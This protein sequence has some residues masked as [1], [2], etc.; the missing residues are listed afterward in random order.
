[1]NPFGSGGGEDPRPVDGDRSRYSSRSQYYGEPETRYGRNRS[2]SGRDADRYTTSERYPRAYSRDVS[3]D[4]RYYGSP[5]RRQSYGRYH[6]GGSLDRY[7]TSRSRFSISQYGDY[8]G[9][10]NGRVYVDDRYY[11][12]EPRYLDRYSKYREMDYHGPSRERMMPR[13]DDYGRS[14]SR[15]GYDRPMPIDR[16]ERYAYGSGDRYAYAGDRDYYT[17]HPSDRY[18]PSYE[19]PPYDRYGPGSRYAIDRYTIRYGLDRSHFEDHFLQDRHARYPR[20]QSTG[21]RVR[22]DSG[23]QY[24]E[25]Q[26]RG[27]MSD[28]QD[29]F[30]TRRD[31]EPRTESVSRDHSLPPRKD[32]EEDYRTDNVANINRKFEPHLQEIPT[33]LQQESRQESRRGSEREERRGSEREERRGSEREERR[34]SERE[35]RRGSERQFDMQDAGTGGGSQTHISGQFGSQAGSER[36][37]TTPTPTFPEPRSTYPQTM[38]ISWDDEENYR[39]GSAARSRELALRASF[40][41]MRRRPRDPSVDVPQRRG[42]SLEPEL[43]IPLPEDILKVESSDFRPVENSKGHRTFEYELVNDAEL[44][45]PVYRRGQTFR[46]HVVLKERELEQSR[47]NMY[48]NFFFGPTPSVPKRTRVVLPIV[49]GAEFQR[50]PYQWDAR[51]L[52]TDGTAMIIEVN[53]PSSCPVGLW[54]CVIETSSADNPSYRL[55]YRC[56]DDVYIIFNPFEREDTV[57]MENDEQRYEYVIN[58]TGKIYTGGYR[59]VRGRPWV[60]GQFDECVLPAACVLLEM[61]GLSHSERG[62]PVKVSRAIA[63]MI[64]ATRS[65]SKVETVWDVI[66]PG[67]IEPRF[68][69][70][71]LRVG[72]S[73]H[74]WTGSVQIIEEFLKGGAAPVKYAQCWVMAA[75]MTSLCRALGL[76]ARPVTAYV[77]ALDTQD[78]LTVDRYIDRFGDI[79]EHG[80]SRDQPDSV[81]SFHTWCDVWMHRPDQTPEYSGWQATDPCRTYRDFRDLFSGSCGPCPIEA[82]R[83][84]DIGQRDDVDAFYASLNSYVRYFYEDDESGWGFSPFKQFRYPVSRYILTKSV[85]RFDDDGDNDCDD[86]T[87]VYRDNELT[88]AERFAIFNS[89]RGL[90]KDTPAYEYK[91]AAFDLKQFDPDQGDQKKFDVSFELDAPERVMVGQPLIVPV[92]V[93][94]SAADPRT[95]QLNICTRSSYYTGNLGPYLKRSTTQ[96]CLATDQHETITLTLDPWDYEEKLVDMSFVRITVTGFVQETSQSFVDEFDFRFM[97]P[98]INIEV[99]EVRVNEEAL[100]TFT[101]TNPLEIPLTECFMTMEVSGSVRPRTVRID[102]EVRPRETFA[103][104]Q[105]FIARAAGKRRFV[106]CFASRQLVDVVGQRAVNIL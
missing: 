19:Y 61:S 23:C 29:G 37:P 79:L 99:P 70:E 30:V 102:R 40:D 22:F 16:Y 83:R 44:P 56:P 17:P 63:S 72:S 38:A 77:S 76:P 26:R 60:Y 86:L 47:D 104:S 97:K 21:S 48:L 51:V 103:H 96:L 88:E 45:T 36:M 89:C 39:P 2:T 49:P 35:E 43:L 91:A 94:N 57:F 24:R 59:N 100:A 50:V 33:P 82:L 105:P 1:M 73:P 65:N 10:R 80:P 20:D 71:D 8:Y 7:D 64:K 31:F 95:I 78:S 101:F 18:Y 54:R 52:S 25:D 85:G 6:Y 32:A 92:I 58:D 41:L 68:E 93:T 90:G 81:W 14:S 5:S 12:P 28:I 15:Y 66:S 34:G 74:L 84:G 53:I 42:T 62:N 9:E 3:R 46:L 55:Q 27:S 69:K 67:L 13:R 75:L 106:A 4:C 11:R 87:N 98:W